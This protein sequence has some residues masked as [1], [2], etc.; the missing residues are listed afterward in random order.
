M[1]YK[2]RVKYEETP[3]ALEPVCELFDIDNSDITIKFVIG[4]LGVVVL[5]F[6][7]IYGNPGGGTPAG[8]VAFF[9]KYLVSWAALGIAALIIN[10]TVWRKA[11]RATA[12]GDAEEIYKF[13]KTK[14]G[15]NTTSQIDFYEDYFESVTKIKIRTF[16][17]VQVTRLLETERGLG[18]VVKKD[19]DV[20][21]SVRVMIGFPK[22]ALMDADIEELKSFLLEKCTGVKSKIKQL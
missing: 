1:T 12:A 8:L 7:F 6:M 21:G 17:Y 5:V 10:R 9:V 15:E 4:G 13:R 20:R 18:L 2:Y 22:D 11:V 16:E 3:E 19:K 14:E